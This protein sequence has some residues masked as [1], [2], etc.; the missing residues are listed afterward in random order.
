VK[1]IALEY[2]VGTDRKDRRVWFTSKDKAGE[3][4]KEIR[5]RYRGTFVAIR[6]FPIHFST[7]RQ[8][9][10]VFLNVCESGDTL[11]PESVANPPAPSPLSEG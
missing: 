2:R 10:A 6:V 1:L 9:F 8:A 5:N 11:Q 7:T 4:A 3:R